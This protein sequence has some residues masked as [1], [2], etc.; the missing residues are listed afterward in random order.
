[1][2][3]PF[4]GELQTM[5]SPPPKSQQQNKIGSPSS[6]AWETNEWTELTCSGV[7]ARSV[8]DL[9]REHLHSAWRTA[10]PEPQSW[11]PLSVNFSLFFWDSRTSFPQSGQNCTRL[12]GEAAGM[13]GENLRTLPHLHL[14]G[15]SVTQQSA[16]ANKPDGV[17][18]W[19]QPRLA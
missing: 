4:P 14:C 10:C 11:N 18:P 17:E 9:T 7:T 19:E 3:N 13:S 5:T 1:M 8:G 15:D 12:A 6:S 2:E 16:A